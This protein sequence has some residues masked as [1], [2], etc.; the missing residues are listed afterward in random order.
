M[1]PR[2]NLWPNGCASGSEF[3]QNALSFLLATV[4]G[5]LI[6]ELGLRALYPIT[7]V[8]VEKLGAPVGWSISPD[9]VLGWHPKLGTR[10]DYPNGYDENGIHVS[11]SIYA[12]AA[13]PK[14]LLIGDSVTFRAQIV[15][16]LA[17]LLAPEITFLN[18]GVYG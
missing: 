6:I 9:P 7:F 17:N 3:I 11:R 15:N 10:L 13:D 5:V 14:L 12:K 2:L 1:S 16:G 18:G 8:H 4:I